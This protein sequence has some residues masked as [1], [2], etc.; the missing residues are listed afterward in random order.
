MINIKHIISTVPKTT[1]KIDG[2]KNKKLL[3]I[4][5]LKKFIF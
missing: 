5:D 2:L 4:L 1:K 3:N